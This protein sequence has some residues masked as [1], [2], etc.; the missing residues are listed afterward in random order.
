MTIDPVSGTLRTSARLDHETHSS[1]LLNVQA[2]AGSP[3][4]YGHAQVIWLLSHI[5]FFCVFVAGILW[6]GLPLHFKPFVFERA[7][8]GLKER[9]FEW[10][11]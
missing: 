1:L 2:T 8:G 7:E 4:A 3:P 11:A 9:K 6:N 10:S 5:Y